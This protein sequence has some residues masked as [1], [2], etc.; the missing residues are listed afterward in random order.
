MFLSQI[1]LLLLYRL[2]RDESL[3]HGELSVLYPIYAMNFIWV[4]IMSPY[5]FETDSMNEV[6]WVGVLAIVA[7]VALIGLGSIGEDND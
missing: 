5:F 2:R 4:S 6:K 7:G 1:E 3:K